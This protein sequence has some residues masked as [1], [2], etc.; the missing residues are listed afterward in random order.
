MRLADE[1]DFAVSMVADNKHGVLFILTKNGYL[2]L[3]EIQE[4]RRIFARRVS[5]QSLFSAVTH[6]ETGGIVTIDQNGRVMLFH[7]DEENLLSYI[8]DSLHDLD[9]GARMVSRF[10]PPNADG[11]LKSIY[12]SHF[13]KYDD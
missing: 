9:F 7:I 6:D 11:I 1:D 5:Q 3:Y 2:L 13:D 4:K 8:A 12:Q 10:D